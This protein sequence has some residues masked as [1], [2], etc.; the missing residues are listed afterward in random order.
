L[1]QED[2]N[3]PSRTYPSKVLLLGEH[4]VMMGSGALAI[5]YN[6]YHGRWNTKEQVEYHWW[7]PFIEFIAG[8]QLPFLVRERLA[9]LKY[10]GNL[11]LDIP[12]GYG[13]GSSGALTAAIY[14]FAHSEEMDDLAEL[15]NR[16]GL[17]ESFFHGES[18]GYDPLISFLNKGVRKSSS[19]QMTLWNSN[20]S[21]N[22][23][24]YLL[25]SGN[26]RIGKE[27]IA[28]VQ[29]IAKEDSN[30]FETVTE[31][32]NQIIAAMSDNAEFESI[33]S[34]LN[35]LSIEQFEKMNFLIVPAMQE[36]WR[37]TLD[38]GNISIKICGAGGGGYY[39]LFSKE[40]LSDIAGWELQEVHLGSNK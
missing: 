22:I 35:Q 19:G 28:K 29:K 24:C 18:S 27:Q 9:Y 12:I 26:P 13:L 38:M 8:L 2:H 17:M 11:F 1:S 25:D 20:F 36:L 7:K 39:L 6:R 31:L 4:T 10:N 37:S 16:L 21:G 5:P 23:H 14:D 15:Q 34:G 40:A 3:F 33:Y 32:N 30:R